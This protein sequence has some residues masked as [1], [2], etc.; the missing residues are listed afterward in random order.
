MAGNSPTLVSSTVGG[1]V[2]LMIGFCLT[3]AA[4]IDDI[5][6][7]HFG[8]QQIGPTY[9]LVYNYS[10][11]DLGP[12]DVYVELGSI[13]KEGNFVPDGRVSN[14]IRIQVDPAPT[15][16][17]LSRSPDQ[18]EAVI[19][20]GDS[21]GF[22]IS[23]K[24]DAWVHWTWDDTPIP[25]KNKEWIS[26]SH[27]YSTA[28]TYNPFLAVNQDGSNLEDDWQFQV[29]VL[30]TYQMGKLGNMVIGVQGNPAYFWVSDKL[31][32]L[33]QNQDNTVDSKLPIFN[34]PKITYLWCLGDGPSFYS[35]KILPPH[36][37]GS[38]GSYQVTC[39]VII[40]NTT[41]LTLSK[42][43][44]VLDNPSIDIVSVSSTP[45]VTTIMVTGKG[46]PPEK[47]ITL[48]LYA[49]DGTIIDQ[50]SVMA[51]SNGQF[52]NVDNLLQP[53]KLAP[54]TYTIT[55]QDIG[56]QVSQTKIFTVT[57]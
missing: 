51:I 55:A 17:F 43:I 39:S 33:V 56:N 1:K 53:T 46:F 12:Y 4:R 6:L 37:Y 9:N 34:D 57:Q 19:M 20:E 52:T 42:T 38:S 7:W 26:P 28:G 30:P 36:K 48:T 44:T 32:F 27:R 18:W 16:N 15:L 3:N 35:D 45:S 49:S 50:N 14:K 22:D 11:R 47:S 8:N 54:G 13:D 2:P 5:K 25:E 40:G 29:L 21:V 10:F 24:T 23:L 31:Y 41:W